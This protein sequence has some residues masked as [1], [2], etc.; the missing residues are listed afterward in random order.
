M[1]GLDIRMID[2]GIQSDHRFVRLFQRYSTNKIGSFDRWVK[3][4]HGREVYG[5][6]TRFAHQ[7]RDVGNYHCSASLIG[8][9]I[10]W[11][12]SV[13]ERTNGYKFPTTTCP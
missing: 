5:L 10:R 3:G 6:F 12:M 7:W 2:N 1:P 4:P 13:D 8:N 11:E 9:R